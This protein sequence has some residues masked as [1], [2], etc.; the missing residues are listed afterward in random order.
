[1][2]ESETPQQEYGKKQSRHKKIEV[3][4]A[5]HILIKVQ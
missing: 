1:M 5:Y 2:A 4:M 3:A